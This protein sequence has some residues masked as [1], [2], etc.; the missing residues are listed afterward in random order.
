MNH[1]RVTELIERYF[2]GTTTLKEEADLKAYFLREDIDPALEVYAPLFRYWVR[3]SEVR[4]PQR[5]RK[6]R[7]RRL[8]QLLLALAAALALLLVARTVHRWENPKVT[9]FPVA[10]RQP[11]DW[12]RHEIT[13]EKEAMRFLHGVLKSTSKRITQAP[14]ITLHELREVERMLD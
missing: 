13:D 3:E 10:E 11:V 5:I 4:A 12:S 7:P 14:E 6:A 8:P 9:T 2:D 1:Q